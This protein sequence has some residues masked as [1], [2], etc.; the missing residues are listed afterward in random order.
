MFA[1]IKNILI[2]TGIAAILGTGV[3]SLY[4]GFDY[5]NIYKNANVWYKVSSDPSNPG[6]MKRFYI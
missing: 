2:I 6:V 3:Y 5:E 4:G 1:K